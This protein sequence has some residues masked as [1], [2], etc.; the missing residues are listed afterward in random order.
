MVG[1]HAA[2]TRQT[3]RGRTYAGESLTDLFLAIFKVHGLMLTRG[4][5]LVRPLNLSSNQWQVLSSIRDR[6]LTMAQ[7]ARRMGLTRQGVRQVTI[8][9][10]RKGVVELTSNPD[11]LRAHLVGLTPAGRQLLKRADSLQA[12]WVNRLGSRLDL[13]GML[14]ARRTLSELCSVLEWQSKTRRPARAPASNE[15]GK[16]SV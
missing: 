5:E 7:I 15:R 13:D 11:H 4:D 9:L 8:R 3:K 16:A 14:R 10:I 1:G 2:T 12:R 6:P